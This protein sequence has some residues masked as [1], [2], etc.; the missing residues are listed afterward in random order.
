[1]DIAGLRYRRLATR[2]RESAAIAPGVENRT[3]LLR[4]AKCLERRASEIER[5]S[6]DETA[7][8]R[9]LMPSS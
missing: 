6:T 8:L 5:Q 9:A 2:F 1:M 7:D 3:K 4:I